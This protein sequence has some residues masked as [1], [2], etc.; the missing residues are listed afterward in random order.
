MA[1][2][3]EKPYTKEQRIDFV[4]QYNRKLG[5]SIE[6][7]DKALFALEVDEIIQ[8]GEPIK[9]PN[10][11]VV[12]PVLVTEEQFLQAFFEIPNYGWFRRV[13][14]GYQS[15]VESVNT[16]F[17]AVNVIGSLPEGYLTFYTKPDFTDE[18]QCTQEWILDNKYANGY[19]TKEQFGEFYIAFM[20]G[21]NA[22][23]HKG[24]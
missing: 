19:M 2:K 20:T 18:T 5:L 3:L 14:R 21:W 1:Y 6:E 10:Y 4:T 12:K 9:D 8:D 17:N 23:E 16:A 13:P 15:A 22:Q 7:T 11:G 24:E